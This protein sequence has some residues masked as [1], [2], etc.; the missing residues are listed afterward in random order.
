MAASVNTAVYE[1]SHGRKPRGFGHWAFE[2]MTG[3]GREKTVVWFSGN[4]G[5]GAKWARTYARQHGYD[6]RIEVMP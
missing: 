4:Y 5:D 3:S 1:Y 2:V 6:G